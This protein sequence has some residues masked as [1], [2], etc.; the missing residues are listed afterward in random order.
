[1]FNVFSYM[2]LQFKLN[3]NINPKIT[4]RNSGMDN[5]AELKFPDFEYF[6]MQEKTE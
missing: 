2:I 6:F 4:P 5:A 3:P 1:M